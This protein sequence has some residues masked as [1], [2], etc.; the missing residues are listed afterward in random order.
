MSFKIYLIKLIAIIS[1][2]M[3]SRLEELL[4]KQ[5]MLQGQILGRMN[6]DLKNINCIT[7]MEFSVF[8]QMG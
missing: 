4:E 2:R 6:V 7:D 3:T 1:K 8:S 5:V